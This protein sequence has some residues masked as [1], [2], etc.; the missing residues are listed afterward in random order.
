MTGVKVR[1]YAGLIAFAAFWLPAHAAG[2]ANSP[3]FRDCSFVAGIDPDFVKLTGATIGPTGNLMVPNSQSSVTVEASESSDPGDNLGHDTFSVTVTGTGMSPKT[4]SGMGVG[5]VTLTVPL[6]GV[7]PGGQYSLAW[8]AV[9][10]NG[11]HHC[12]GAMTPQ[13]PTSTSN[14]FVL[15]VVAGAAAP[16]PV[17]S[18]LRESH[19]SWREAAGTKFSFR[20]NEPATAMFVFRERL[21]GHLVRRGALMRMGRAGPNSVHFTGKISDGKRLMPGRYVAIVTATNSRGESSRP[22]S[23]SFVIRR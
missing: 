8:A 3:A 20:L 4:V 23:I 16:A 2:A 12:P 15:Q 14:P 9:F 6:G 19:R 21:H 17:V 22:V 7:A 18:K 1:L 10:D 13:N 5:H 11:F